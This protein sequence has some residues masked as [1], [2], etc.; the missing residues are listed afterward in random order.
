MMEQNVY[1][2]TCVMRFYHVP[3]FQGLQSLA[4]VIAIAAELAPFFGG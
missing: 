3:M 4:S 2:V 1:T